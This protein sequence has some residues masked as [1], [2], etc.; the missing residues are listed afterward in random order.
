[1][2]AYIDELWEARDTLNSASL[3]DAAIKKA[4]L[5]TIDSLDNGKVK[6]AFKDHITWKKNDWIQKAIYI[7][8]R[9]MNNFMQIDGMHRFFDNIPLKFDGWDHAK[10]KSSG[11]SVLPGATVRKGAFIS[12][13]AKIMS[14]F[15]DIGSF[16]GKNSYIGNYSTISNF[17][18]I[19]NNVV[20]G[21][22]VGVGGE[23]LT[24]GSD[25][26]TEPTVIEDNVFI[27]AKSEIGEGVIIGEGSI[28]L[29]GS[30]IT[31]HTKVYDRSTD[32]VY[33]GQVPPYSIVTEGVI[34][35]EDI[36]GVI[37]LDILNKEK[38]DNYS[39]IE[40]L[41]MLKEV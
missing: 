41:K 7:Y 15:I 38:R 6:V 13:K 33:I 35:G 32:Q 12:S 10:F 37:I 36:N 8:F 11:I 23:I 5:D 2:K 31:P 34:P 22:G 14:S 20:I 40:I 27:G 18:Y 17:S 4:L 16:V 21:N 30:I 3:N 39:V 24:K 25:F 29:E 9:V 26:L 28:V 19:G 1:M